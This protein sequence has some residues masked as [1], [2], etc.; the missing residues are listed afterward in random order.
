VIR[1]VFTYYVG[2]QRRQAMDDLYRRFLRPGDLAFDVGSHAGDRIA[3]FRRLGARV[4]AVEPQSTLTRLLRLIYGR[5]PS[6]CTESVAVGKRP[7]IAE[8]LINR[9]NPTV[10]SASTEFVSAAKGATGWEGQVWDER[11]RV[12]QTT[13]DAVIGRYGMSAFIKI[14]VEG[15]EAKVLAGLSVPVPALSFELTTI[16]RQVAYACLAACRELGDYRFNAAIGESQRLELDRWTT[17]SEMA[18]WIDVLPH[19]ANSGDIC[20]VRADPPREETR[21]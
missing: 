6:V 5:D 7:G 17:A 11:L 13:L 16:Q 4:V 12:S 8:L 9:A 3:S 15:Y 14:D 20:A 2:K 19:E 1:S 18:A 10:N 21:A